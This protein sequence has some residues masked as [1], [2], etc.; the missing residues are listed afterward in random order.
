MSGAALWSLTSDFMESTLSA[1]ERSRYE[2]QMIMPE[3][4]E[5]GQARLRQAVVFIGGLGGLG[6]VSALYMAASGVGS[7][8]LADGDTVSTGN[9]NRQIIHQTTD[10]GRLKS[11]SAHEKLERLNPHCHVHAMA[12]TITS[13][14][15]LKLVGGAH[16]IIDG[17]DNIRTRKVLNQ[18]AIHLDIPF[19]YGGINGF[20]G[21][22]STFIPGKT[23]CFDCLFSKSRDKEAT[24]GVIGPIPG[25]TASIQCMEAIKILV[26]M[27]PSLTDCLLVINGK[28]MTFRKISITRNSNCTSCRLKPEKEK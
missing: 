22:V 8:R 7:L 5:T 25:V 28:D 12:E 3:I 19:I 13:D 18:A 17:T 2:R 21:T 14:N 4:G 20:D 9:L 16:I 10:I 6:S 11:V 26:G 23:A 1:G 27:G 24:I 15:V